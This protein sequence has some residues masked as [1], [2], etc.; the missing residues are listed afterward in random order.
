M[1][2]NDEKTVKIVENHKLSPNYPDIMIHMSNTICV[3]RYSY[4]LS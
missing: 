1:A 4:S 3:P 2:L